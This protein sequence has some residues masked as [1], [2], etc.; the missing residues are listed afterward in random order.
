MGIEN[1]E[2]SVHFEFKSFGKENF[3]KFIELVDD[4]DR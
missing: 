3:M 4:T 1:E 2:I